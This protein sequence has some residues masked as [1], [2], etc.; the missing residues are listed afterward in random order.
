MT[1]GKETRGSYGDDGEKTQEKNCIIKRQTKEQSRKRYYRFI[2][3]S[4]PGSTQGGAY[5]RPNDVSLAI[6]DCMKIKGYI[7]YHLG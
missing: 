1:A 7:G 5:F 4:R 3:L 2:E 6:A